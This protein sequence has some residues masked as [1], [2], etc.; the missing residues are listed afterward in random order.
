MNKKS[1]KIKKFFKKI[2]AKDVK[3]FTCQDYIGFGELKNKI[4]TGWTVIDFTN[5]QHY[6]G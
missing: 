4:L 5:G 2:G 6:I 1:G 3:K